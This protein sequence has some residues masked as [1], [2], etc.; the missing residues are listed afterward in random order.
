MYLVLTDCYSRNEWFEVS[1]QMEKLGFSGRSHSP[2]ELNRTKS[3]A[4]QW[5]GGCLQ[6]SVE[7]LRLLQVF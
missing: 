2:E 5:A 4:E 1:A 6:E 7:V 3:M